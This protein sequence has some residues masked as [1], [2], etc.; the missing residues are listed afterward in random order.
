MSTYIDYN[1]PLFRL[2]DFLYLFFKRLKLAAL[3][4][5]G[6]IANR[7]SLSTNNKYLILQ[8]LVARSNGPI[9]AKGLLR[10]NILTILLDSKKQ[11]HK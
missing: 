7:T 10:F 11:Y 9:T 5:H 2:K 3:K 1:F 8:A 4:S 6:L